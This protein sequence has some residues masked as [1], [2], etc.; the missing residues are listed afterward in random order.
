MSGIG[1]TALE[2]GEFDFPERNRLATA[3]IEKYAVTH[4]TVDAGIG[5]AGFLPVP[6]AATASII[7]SMAVQVP[8]Y[9]ALARDLAQIYESPYDDIA[10]GIVRSGVVIG[11][12]LE[13]GSEMVS[14]FGMEFAQEIG[15]EVVK[16]IGF[17]LFASLIPVLGGFVSTG[18]DIAIATTMTWRV[19]TMIAI[20]YQ[21]GGQWVGSRHQT[22]E[23]A[24]ELTGGLS[25]R[26]EKRVDLDD[27]PR[28]VKPVGEYQTSQLMRF[29]QELLKC[30]PNLTDAMIREILV[31][32]G[33]L[34]EIANDVIRR[35]LV[36][37]QVVLP[38]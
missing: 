38:S 29:V 5:L 9:R 23:H 8:I 26:V 17:G 16:E 7:A 25:E 28:K 11:S 31:T 27:V 12:A 24:K 33:V 30:A 34:I 3:A 32:K 22:Y 6:G 15:L 20:Y 10:K 36:A 19:G 14:Q 21:N 18:L 4:A 13:L 37:T 35:F 1:V 2:L